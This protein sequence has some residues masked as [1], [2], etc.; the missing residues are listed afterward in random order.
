MKFENPIIKTEYSLQNQFKKHFKANRMVY[1]VDVGRSIPIYTHFVPKNFNIE[2][3]KAKDF[4]NNH[5]NNITNAYKQFDAE[6]IERMLISEADKIQSIAKGNMLTNK[7]LKYCIDN[8]IIN[9][10]TIKVEYNSSIRFLVNPYYK[11]KGNEFN[12]R[13]KIKYKLIN[14]YLGNK[15]K[16]VNYEL[17]QNCISDHDCNRGSI[18]K[19]SL[20]NDC[21]LSLRT[22]NN[23]LKE[24]LLLNEFFNKVKEFSISDKQTIRK[25]YNKAS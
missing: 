25:Q 18:T 17:I 21:K 5:L 1:I 16:I 3:W 14:G 22:I 20:S 8:A 7:Y 13:K 19:L 23:Y 4:L 6:I 24:Y 15:K 10:D 11:F 9:R 2:S 12:N